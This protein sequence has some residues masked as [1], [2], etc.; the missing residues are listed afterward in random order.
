MFITLLVN[1]ALCSIFV[2]TS[3]RDKKTN[4]G[5]ITIIFSNFKLIFNMLKKILIVFLIVFKVGLPVFS[6]D[7][8]SKYVKEGRFYNDLESA[9]ANPYN[10]YALQIY[11]KKPEM[12]GEVLLDEKI[13]VFKNLRYLS[14]NIKRLPNSFPSLENLEM[15]SIGFI[16]GTNLDSVF[17]VISKLPNL[18]SLEITTQIDYLPA[19]IANNNSLIELTIYGFYSV[20]LP[21]EL[22]KMK[23]LKRFSINQHIIHKKLPINIDSCVEVLKDMPDLEYV[24]FKHCLIK[25]FPKNL[26]KLKQIETLDLSFNK[27][28]KLPNASLSGFDKLKEIWLDYNLISK[29]NLPKDNITRILKDN[30]E[31]VDVS[32]YFNPNRNMRFE[33]ILKVR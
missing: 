2:D 1:V 15:L 29:K 8:I 25:E 11:P 3:Y 10:V 7:Y 9:F 13:L 4:E 32:L 22:R 31:Y 19:I 21:T 16:K 14:I 20:S 23:G 24:A 27:I 30:G 33:N 6:Q 28:K 17:A 26:H 18:K 12:L 5:K